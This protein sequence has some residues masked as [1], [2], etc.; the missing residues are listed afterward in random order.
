MSGNSSD[1]SDEDIGQKLETF[2]ESLSAKLLSSTQLKIIPFS[3]AP[4]Q[5]LEEWL[6]NYEFAASGAGWDEEKMA[7]R[8]GA[9]LMGP[10]RLWYQDNIKDSTNTYTYKGIVKMMCNDFLSSGYKSHLRDRVRKRRQGLYESVA[11]Y[12]FTMRNLLNRMDKDNH[13]DE[14]ERVERVL[15][16]MLPQ[17][18][19]QVLPYEPKTFEILLEKAKLVEKALKRAAS[20]GDHAHYAQML[21]EPPARLK[22]KEEKP[23]DWSKAM[24]AMTKTFSEALT[25]IAKSGANTR[26]E[27]RIGNRGGRGGYQSRRERSQQVRDNG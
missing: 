11:N 5:D 9:H 10:A 24:E 25:K 21:D 6:M 15:E 20:E 4:N 2:G 13:L 22:V 8:I 19:A 1:A 12:I 3:N 7:A 23:N 26:D 18:A 17:I 14:E 16:G 27:G